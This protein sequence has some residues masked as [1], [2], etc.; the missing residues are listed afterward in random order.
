MI[1]PAKLADSILLFRERFIPGS[2]SFAL[3]EKLLG[4]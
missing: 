4:A 1:K 2:A 3:Q